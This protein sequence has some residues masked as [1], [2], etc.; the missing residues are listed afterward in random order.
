M[1]KIRRI[2]SSV[3]IRVKLLTRP[4][5]DCVWPCQHSRARSPHAFGPC[6]LPMEPSLTSDSILTMTMENKKNRKRKR[7]PCWPTCWRRSSACVAPP[8]RLR[9]HPPHLRDHGRRG[10]QWQLGQWRSRAALIAAERGMPSRIVA[11]M[12][13]LMSHPATA[14]TCALRPCPRAMAM[15][16]RAVLQCRRAAPRQGPSGPWTYCPS[17]LEMTTTP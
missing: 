16:H 3:R 13:T 14:S 10:H 6:R 1:T 4:W 8:S 7:K 12:T 17:A 11:R 9:H 2:R 5:M 15:V